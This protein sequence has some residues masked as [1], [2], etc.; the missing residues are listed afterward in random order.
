MKRFSFVTVVIAVVAMLSF[1][2]SA[3]ADT[4]WESEPNNS[5][6][7]ANVMMVDDL[8]VGQ[9]SSSA[10]VDYYMFGAGDTE[11]ITALFLN[12]ASD[13][14]KHYFFVWDITSGG[15]LI[16][17][18]NDMVAGGY[19]SYS[20]DLLAGHVYL[21]GVSAEG[22]ASNPYQFGLFR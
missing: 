6:S 17:N 7:T 22:T 1:S 16:V 5:S 8:A 3:F 10:D 14:T 2:Q 18:G 21:I 12:Q 15:Q 11:T 19:K 20:I 4:V 9:I 13:L